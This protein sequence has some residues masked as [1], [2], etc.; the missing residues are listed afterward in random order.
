MTVY[1]NKKSHSLKW[2]IAF[3]I[4]ALAMTITWSDVYGAQ[5]M[6]AASSTIQVH[7]VNVTLFSVGQSRFCPNWYPGFPKPARTILASVNRA[8]ALSVDVEV[9]VVGTSKP[10]AKNVLEI[11]RKDLTIIS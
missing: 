10:P 11:H 6:T 4:F 8:L 9:D 2:L 5:T 1:K 3:I 7:Q